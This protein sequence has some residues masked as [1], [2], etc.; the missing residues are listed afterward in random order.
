MILLFWILKKLE[1]SQSRLNIIYDLEKKHFVN[2]LEDLLKIRD[3]IDEK[4]LVSSNLTDKIEKLKKEEKEIFVKL[5]AL[6]KEITK[7]RKES[8]KKIEKEILPLLSDMGMTEA[9][10]RINIFRKPDPNIKWGK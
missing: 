4:L 8:A 10:L 6:A 9:V 3:E 7:S 1:D 5:S 2:S